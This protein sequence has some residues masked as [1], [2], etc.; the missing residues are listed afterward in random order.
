MCNRWA[1]NHTDEIQA[2]W[3]N[4]VGVE[5]V[6]PSMHQSIRAH[7]ISMPLLAERGCV[8]TAHAEV[9][10]RMGHLQQNCAT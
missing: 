1:H 3:I 8:R 2:A 4:G 5:T 7:G 9:G 10:K 6:S